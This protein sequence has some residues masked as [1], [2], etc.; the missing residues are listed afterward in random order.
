MFADFECLLQSAK[1]GDGNALRTRG[2]HRH[3]P[4]QAAIYVISTFDDSFKRFELYRPRSHQYASDK[5]GYL[6]SDVGQWVVEM[7]QKLRD[8]FVEHLKETGISHYV[9]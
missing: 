8:A 9:C 3:I 1:T 2:T 5:E 7:V 6:V 4:P